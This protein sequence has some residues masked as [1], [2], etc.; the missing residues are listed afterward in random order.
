V[1]Q[2]PTTVGANAIRPHGR[3]WG[4]SKVGCGKEKIPVTLSEAN[5]VCE[6]SPRPPFM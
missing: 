6:L 3:L 2:S 4:R 1:I 5:A